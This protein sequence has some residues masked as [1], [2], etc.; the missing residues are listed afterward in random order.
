MTL[1]GL[2]RTPRTPPPSPPA[3]GPVL[4]DEESNRG[5][6]EEDYKRIYGLRAFSLRIRVVVSTGENETKTISACGRESF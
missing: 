3:Y 4:G 1:G 5:R 6:M 2:G